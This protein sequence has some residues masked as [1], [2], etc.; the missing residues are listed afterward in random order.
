MCEKATMQNPDIRLF[1]KAINEGHSSEIQ[2]MKKLQEEA[3]KSAAYQIT[4]ANF[5]GVVVVW[6]RVD[7]PSGRAIC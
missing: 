3:S 7:W 6:R 4:D 5:G 1:C 2:L